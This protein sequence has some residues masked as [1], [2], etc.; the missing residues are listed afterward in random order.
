M[1]SS[2]NTR[3][4][5]QDTVSAESRSASWPITKLAMCSA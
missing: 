1:A 3:D 5:M 2:S 4:A